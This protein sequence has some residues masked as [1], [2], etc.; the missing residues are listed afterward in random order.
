MCDRTRNSI[1]LIGGL[2]AL[3]SLAPALSAIGLPLGR[4]FQLRDPPSVHETDGLDGHHLQLGLLNLSACR[5]VLS[6]VGQSLFGRSGIKCGADDAA[7]L[8]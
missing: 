2:A 6:Q 1:G 3:L 4:A 7:R 5:V 8:L